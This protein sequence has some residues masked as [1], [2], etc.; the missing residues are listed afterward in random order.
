VPLWRLHD[1]VEAR[2]A[3]IWRQQILVD[4]A[5][6]LLAILAAANRVWFS[7]FQFKRLRKLVERLDEVPPGLAE[8]LESLF[9]LEPR[10]AA[11]ELQRLVD[12]TDALLAAHGLTP[13]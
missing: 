12:E 1:H 6:D 9:L 10:A 3:L 5:L 2:D 13:G 11:E 4:A 8:R 7:S